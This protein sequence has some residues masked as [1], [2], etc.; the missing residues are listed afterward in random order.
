MTAEEK[1][2]FL[3]EEP[4]LAVSV[5][6]KHIKI[7]AFKAAR[8]NA[9][10]AYLLRKEKRRV[11]DDNALSNKEKEMKKEEKRN[12]EA[13]A[14]FKANLNHPCY[15]SMDELQAVLQELHPAPSTLPKY[16]DAMKCEIVC[17][18]LRY[19]EA[20]LGRVLRRGCLHSS[21]KGGSTSKLVLLLESFAEVVKDEEETPALLNPPDVRKTYQA[22]VFATP[23]RLELDQ[24]RTKKTVELTKQ[25][26]DE[27]PDG[28]FTAH[29]CT[30][31]YSRGN[32]L[33]PDALKGERIGKMFHPFGQ[34]EGE[35]LEF[36]GTI[37]SYKPK[38]KWWHVVFDDGEEEDY[39]F[40]QLYALSTPPDFSLLQPVPPPVEAASFL[41]CTDGK[42]SG[43]LAAPSD[44]NALE[45]F[46][47]EDTEYTFIS[48]FFLTTTEPFVGA[49]IEDEDFY[50]NLRLLSYD[51]LKETAG[52]HITPMPQLHKWIEDSKSMAVGRAEESSSSTSRRKR[53][54]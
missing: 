18:Q 47:L 11:A 33:N 48:V 19:R 44:L 54:L 21:H 17:G 15:K 14:K 3:A 49:Y 20:C 30:V 35:M 53:K 39:N 4:F 1:E 42:P 31:D 29:R 45:D 12:A 41:N 43:A 37:V 50:H 9:R 34:T 8:K 5:L 27:Y 22:A 24:T 16:S 38:K 23:L 13:L 51:E 46:R 7:K 26:N 32:A 2:T 40:R 10:P 52:V 36:L 28:L 25:F 6:P